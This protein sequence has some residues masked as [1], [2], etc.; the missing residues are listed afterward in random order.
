MYFWYTNFDFLMY[1]HKA[2]SPLSH[3]F[4]APGEK[5]RSNL[6]VNLYKMCLRDHSQSVESEKYTNQ[7]GHITLEAEYKMILASHKHRPYPDV[8]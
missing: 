6:G 3:T 4:F 2:S 5:I 8:V 1:F 7:N